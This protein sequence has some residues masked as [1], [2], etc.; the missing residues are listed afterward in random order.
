MLDRLIYGFSSFTHN[1]VLST[2][3]NL[4]PVL[5]NS[6]LPPKVLGTRTKQSNYEYPG[7]TP[8]IRYNS[9]KGDT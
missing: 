8:H 1:I 5:R 7:P 6:L 4:F 3:K 2:L 9:Q